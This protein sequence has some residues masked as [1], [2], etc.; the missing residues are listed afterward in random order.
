MEIKIVA[1]KSSAPE[2]IPPR[3]EITVK[4][5][6]L[7]LS[8]PKRRQKDLA[9]NAR[10]IDIITVK[11]MAEMMFWFKICDFFNSGVKVPIWR[12]EPNLEPNAPNMFPL[13]PIA[14]GMRTRSPGSISRVLV[15]PFSRI[16]AIK[17]PI[18]HIKRAVNVSPKTR[19]TSLKKLLS[20]LLMV[21]GTWR[22]FKDLLE[23]RT[24]NLTIKFRMMCIESPILFSSFSV[25]F[26]EPP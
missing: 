19:D 15:I 18:A 22:I 5:T 26:T 13:I 20:L 1:G 3:T 8:N 7:I 14:P 9:A 16:P 21:N 24:A 10:K 23:T 6:M 2:N 12:F 4:S 11:I 25:H 17:S